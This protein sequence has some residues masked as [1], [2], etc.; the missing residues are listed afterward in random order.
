MC[1][2]DLFQSLKA[3]F[4]SEY[5][6]AKTDT[7]PPLLSSY[8]CFLKINE[9]EETSFIIVTASVYFSEAVT[10]KFLTLLR[11]V[12]KHMSLQEPDPL[13]KRQSRPNLVL[14]I[15]PHKVHNRHILS[16]P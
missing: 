2:S 3:L 7:T 10:N 16:Y 5:K 1:S 8:K 13:D 15:H 4:S 14:D 11:K 12:Y 9:N 6:P